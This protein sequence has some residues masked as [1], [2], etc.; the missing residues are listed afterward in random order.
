MCVCV[1]VCVYVCSYVCETEAW[2]IFI[3]YFSL[4]GH[5]WSDWAWALCLRSKINMKILKGFCQLIAIEK[6]HGNQPTG[7]EKRKDK[8]ITSIFQPNMLF[9][10]KHCMYLIENLVIYT[11]GW[12]PLLLTVDYTPI[13][14]DFEK[15][16]KKTN[17]ITKFAISRLLL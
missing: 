17:I 4:Y 12:V 13:K 8:C 9:H 14:C 10:Y 11:Y 15:N 6:C 5:D 16:E 2:A 7:I 3:Y 1:C